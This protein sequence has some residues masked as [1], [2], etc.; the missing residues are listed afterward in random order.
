MKT[1]SCGC[2]FDIVDGKIAYNPDIER[3]PLHCQDTWDLICSG[4]TK[5]VFQLESQLGRSMSERVKPRNME[6][7]SDYPNLAKNTENV[8]F[9]A[10]D[11][12]LLKGWINFGTSNQAILLLQEI[13]KSHL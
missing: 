10:A 8:E 13:R 1:F 12:T 11:G 2:S 4:N 3:L 6:E 5:G 7:L 9:Q